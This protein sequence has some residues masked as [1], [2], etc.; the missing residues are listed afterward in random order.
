MF[1][2]RK[3]AGQQ[4]ASALETYARGTGIV[5]AIPRG[6]VEVGYYVARRLKLPFSMAVVRKLPFPDNPEAGFGAIAEDGSVYIQ[7]GMIST[8]PTE[9]IN[10][11]I[12]RQQQE[13][14]RRIEVLRDG[15]PLPELAGR[16][17]FLVD[18]GIAMGST[19]RAAIA[20]CRNRGAKRIIAAAPVAGPAAVRQLSD[21]ADQ[22]VALD[23]PTHFRAVAQAY[24]HWYD[25]S[26][27]EVRQILNHS[28]DRPD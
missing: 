26:D 3:D 8:I 27:D 17:V 14:R 16:T 19:L 9:T 11:I 12:R 23:V 6:G 10:H 22:V 5:L 7:E 2:D 15:R 28:F 18:D 1:T 13:I 20:L 24:R 21:I 4:L 25:V